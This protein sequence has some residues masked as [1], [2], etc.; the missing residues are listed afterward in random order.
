MTIREDCPEGSIELT[1]ERIIN[2]WDKARVRLDT[3]RK[4]LGYAQ[5]ELQTAIAEELDTWEAVLK[6]RG[7]RPR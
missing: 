6:L 5:E 7:E 1:T 3:A 4:N 2:D